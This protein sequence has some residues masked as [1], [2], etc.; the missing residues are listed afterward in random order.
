LL[1]DILVDG[2]V[3]E[4]GQRIHGGV[5]FHFGFIGVGKAQD[6]LGDAAKLRF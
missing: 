1:G 4:T 6:A 5:N 3:G 2:V